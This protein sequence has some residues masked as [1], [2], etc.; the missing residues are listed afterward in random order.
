MPR[1]LWFLAELIVILLIL[2]TEASFKLKVLIVGLYA[3]AVFF[4]TYWFFSFA[5][6][7]FAWFSLR[8]FSFL[9]CYSKSSLG[10]QNLSTF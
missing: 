1:A 8:R 5:R 6:Y 3:V 2:S 9:A 4:R 10:T 7:R